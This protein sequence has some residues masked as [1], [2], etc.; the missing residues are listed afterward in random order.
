MRTKNLMT[1]ALMAMSAC[2]A[3]AYETPTMGWSSWNTYGFKISEQLIQS[4]ADAVLANGLDKVG[5]KYINIDDGYFGGRNEDGS[6]KFNAERFPNGL[7]PL[8][9]YIH[10]KG[11]KAGIYSDAGRNTC[12]SYFGGDQSGI[13]VGL[14]G[15][16]QQDMDLFFKTLKF[17]FIKVDYCG[18]EPGYNSEGLDLPEENRYREIYQ[19]IVNT[20][21]QDVRLNVCR[22]AFPGTWVHDIATS[23]RTTGDINMSWG[24]VRNIIKENLYLSAFAT[25][26]KF[27]DMDMLE[28]GRG[29]STEEDNTHFAMWCM[30][31]S[32]LLIGCDMTKIPATTLALLK[33]TDLIALNQDPLALQAQVV[34]RTDGAYLLVK[35]TKTLHGNTRACAVYNPTDATVTFTFDFLDLDLGGKVKMRDLCEQKDLGEFAGNYTVT[36]P[37]HGTRVYGLEAEKRYDKVKYEAETAWLS[38]YQELA[39][40][41]SAKTG[42]YEELDACSGGAKAGWL[43]YSEKNDLQWKDI[44]STD[45]GDYKMT[46]SYICGEDRKVNVTVNDE[47]P[48]ELTVNSG[49]WSI[50]KTVDLNIKLNA[51]INKIRLSNANAWMPDID[52]ITLQKANSMDV[53]EH[54]LESMKE[55]AQNSL[56]TAVNEG[57][58]NLLNEALKQADEVTADE[59][60][61]QNAIDQL[62]KAIDA[63]LAVRSEYES[64]AK[65]TTWCDT[66]LKSSQESES[67]T[68]LQGVLA[69]TK[70]DINGATT[71]AE[72]QST[73]QT[74]KNAITTYLKSED[75]KL[76]ADASWDMTI[77]LNNPSFDADTKGWT[78]SATYGHGA[79]EFWNKSFNCYQTL[80]GLKNGKYRVE[81]QALYRLAKNDS[82][83]LYESGSETIPAKFF[84]NDV[85][86]PIVSMYSYKYD[87]S[88]EGF[89][90]TDFKNG[91]VNSMYTASLSFAAGHYENSLEVE[92]TDGKLKIGVACTTNQYDCWCCFD[93]FRL[94]YLGE[95]TNTGITSANASSKDSYC[96]VFSTNGIRVKKH[97][98]R[99]DA[100]KGLPTGQYV[101]NGKVISKK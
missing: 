68:T 26:G 82:G 97:V 7:A 12:A 96:D 23:W 77:L 15:H 54:Q 88:T 65:L 94:T 63:E 73:T 86:T 61:Y 40:N 2:Y 84:A 21:R 56:T 18:A 4:Q 16:D 30:L 69:Q 51:G 25:E 44:Y 36:V 11:L 33:N 92:V 32:P 100:L 52:C 74:L 10:S 3:H 67:L 79:A 55:K 37:A 62:Q 80:T 29:L 35:D 17:D 71:Q 90:S 1:A 19:A 98:K 91:Y 24:S 42:I 87:G 48:V 6:L 43:G 5:Y 28:V 13:G 34:K 46:L 95:D 81:V 9:E 20:G 93:N 99:A 72:A 78:G 58:K 64:F 8:V 53:I 57:V 75:S 45:G 39:N 70:S 31:S 41:Q 101:I 14:Y 59:A 27:N 76:K 89:G 47:E 66:N 60:S 83:A 38:A 85:E 22:W 49:G 50:V